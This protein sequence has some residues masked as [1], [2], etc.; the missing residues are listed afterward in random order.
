MLNDVM[1]AAEAAKRWGVPE[2]TIR[3]SCTGQKGYPPRFQEGEFSKSGNTWLLTR[4]GMNR[5]YGK[6][7]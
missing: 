6:Q 7:R 1:T 4:D 2:N 3:V 5:L